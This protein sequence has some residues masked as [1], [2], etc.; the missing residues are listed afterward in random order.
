MMQGWGRLDLSGCL[1][2]SGYTNPNM[3]I[4]VAD[5][6]QIRQNEA[7]FLTGIVA[8]GTGPIKAVL[9]WHDYPAAAMASTVLVNDL[10]LWYIVNGGTPSK[11]RED[12]VNNVERVELSNLQSGD[13]VA[14]L[15]NGSKIVHNLMGGSQPDAARPQYWAL[16]V[17]GHFK[18]TLK[19]VL[20]PA[21]ARPL[22]LTLLY[23][24]GLCLHAHMHPCLPLSPCY[25]D[26]DWASPVSEYEIW[27][28]TSGDEAAG[29]VTVI[30]DSPVPSISL[31]CNQAANRFI[32]S[33]TGTAT[34]SYVYTVKDYLGRCLT[35]ISDYRSVS[36]YSTTFSDCQQNLWQQLALF[37]NTFFTT[38]VCF[39]PESEL[40]GLHGGVCAAQVIS[41]GDRQS[42]TLNLQHW[43]FVVSRL[44]TA[45]EKY[46]RSADVRIPKT[47]WQLV[48]YALAGYSNTGSDR[49]C[50]SHVTPPLEAGKNGL[51]VYP[52]DICDETDISQAFLLLPTNP[53]MPWLRFK[54]EWF[55]GT[56]RF[57]LSS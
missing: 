28:Y 8:T 29:C 36:G 11:T 46:V 2:L 45:S 38:R 52:P 34:G 4:Q 41:A 19:G 44:Q 13:K 43:C 25:R 30:D 51:Q 53:E 47:V 39:L 50:L 3:R 16:A 7:H 33:E 49:Y 14:L 9:V 54:V 17:V 40:P 23:A 48:P 22:R 6:G 56:G 24:D 15:V 20:N 10:D 18:G 42:T 26:K 12:R 32:L 1:P 31:T 37:K 35:V 27:Q 21:F 5:L 57:L 55:V